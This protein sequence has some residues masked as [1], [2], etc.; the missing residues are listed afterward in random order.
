MPQKKVDSHQHVN[1]HDR[2][3]DGLVQDLDDNKIAYC[4]A[5]T[6]YTEPDDPVVNSRYLNPVNR[7]T[8]GSM[9]GITLPEIIQAKRAYP[10]RFVIGYCPD[11]RWP[12]APELLRAAYQMHGARVCGEWKF[13]TLFEDPR[14]LEIFK[15][16]GE[17]KMPVV[18]HLDLPYLPDEEGNPVYQDTWYGGSVDNLERALQACPETTFIGHAPAFWR[19]IGSGDE[20]DSNSRPRGPVQ[21][22]GKL[23][24]LFEIYPNLVADLSA[25]SGLVAL[26]RDPDHARTFLTQFAD[27]LLFGRDYYGNELE[28]FLRDL[29]LEDS[30]LER[31]FWRNAER[32]VAPPNAEPRSY[33]MT[34]SLRLG[35]PQEIKP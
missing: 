4:W 34:K 13:R 29:S 9:E 3:V 2:D 16:A 30:V 11:P 33:Q 31:I 7:R 23:Y 35:F 27:R 1:W 10:D 5:L 25:G 14:C 18:L 15:V 22:P 24:S 17:L 19:E 32:L 6:W 8:D 21:G 26:Q 20:A 12:D 28:S